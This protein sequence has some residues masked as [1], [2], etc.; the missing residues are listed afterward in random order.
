MTDEGI[1]TGSTWRHKAGLGD[2]ELDGER[3]LWDPET[4]CVARLDR[5]GSLVWACL[6]GESSLD[7][8][9]G[10]LAAGFATPPE[11]VRRDVVTLVARLSEMGL[12]V[13]EPS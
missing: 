4:G 2:A 11:V 5:V 3:V 12:L 9:T 13:E 8:V 7:E 6:D 1:R 10:D